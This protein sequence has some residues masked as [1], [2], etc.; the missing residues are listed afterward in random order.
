M[1]TLTP[2]A[3]TGN[4]VIF[5]ADSAFFVTAHIGRVIVSGSGRATITALGPSAGASGS[6]NTIVRANIT[7]A[8]AGTSAIAD[9]N[10]Q[11]EVKLTPGATTGNGIVFTAQDPVFFASDI[12]RYIISGAGRAIIK[13]LGP[14]AGASSSPNAVVR[15][16]ILDAFTS[17]S[18]IPGGD[19]KLRLSPQT[20]MDV[21]KKEPEGAQVN[22]L[23]G[24]DMFRSADV[25]KFISIYGGLIEITSIT[26]RTHAIG[27]IRSVLVDAD[28]NFD[29]PPISPIGAWSLRVRSWSDERGWPRAVD[30]H[31]GRLVFGGTRSQPT[32]WWASRSNDFNNFAIGALASDGLEYTIADKSVNIIQWL[33]S[34]KNLFIGNAETEHSAKGRGVDAPIGGEEIPYV[35]NEE[36][37]GAMHAQPLVLQRAI[38]FLQSYGRKLVEMA[39]DFNA[40]GYVGNNLMLYSRH[41]GDSKLVQHSPV[42]AKEPHSQVYTIRHDGQM[43]VLTYWRK[44]QVS[45]W[46]RFV[47]DGNVESVVTIPDSIHGHDDVLLVVNRT[48]GGVTKRFIEA[49]VFPTDRSV[50]VG[51]DRAWREFY[52]D[53]A[54]E[55]VLDAGA[56]IIAGLSYLEG[57]SVDVIL[58]GSFVGAF[59]VTSGQI[60]IGDSNVANFDMTYEVGLHYDSLGETM[61]P[62]IQGQTIDGL[63]RQWEPIFFR[64]VKSIGGRVNNRR[65]LYPAAPL[66]GKTLFSGDVRAHSLGNGEDIDGAITFD[67]P[68]PYPIQITAIFGT[69]HVGDMQ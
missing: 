12:G 31:Q 60:N 59:T 49:V 10:W 30:F 26:D 38:L 67:Q 19:W 15:A 24:A 55:G 25:G 2:S 27:E 63:P 62:S 5:T 13:A 68:D 35:I 47:T 69:L 65:L 48:I 41:L 28:S 23:A 64:L 57:K 9:N 61:R 14:S 51:A 46:S 7:A 16:D 18:P 22:L 43:P 40:D 58:N 20:T 8:F 37:A 6:P 52:T 34:S 53:C 54:S 11:L 45:G 17:V 50:G 36:G 21:N 29:D 33:A 42:Y 66:D 32:T 44:E 39:Y 4:G 3:T 56:R 1:P